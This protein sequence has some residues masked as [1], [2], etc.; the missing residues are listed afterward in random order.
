MFLDLENK[1]TTS[2][3]TTTEALQNDTAIWLPFDSSDLWSAETYNP[4]QK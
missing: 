2:A 4:G 3:C 1:G